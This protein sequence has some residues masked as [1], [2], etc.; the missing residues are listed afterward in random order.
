M[1]TS[2]TTQR[3]P[4]SL[5]RHQGP[6]L[7]EIARIALGAAIPIGRPS[8]NPP[9]FLEER[10]VIPA[11]AAELV[12]RYAAWSG[13]PDG[14]ALTLPPHMIAQWSIPLGTKI[15]RQTRYN[16]AT[17]INQGVSLRINGELPRDVPL[18]LGA[19]ITRLEESDGRARVAVSLTTGTEI[20]PRIIEA[21]LESTFPLP[22]ASRPQRKSR[23]VDDAEW[24]TIDHWQT[25][26][27]DGLKFA[28]LTGDFNP[29]H[30]VGIAGRLSPFKA[31]VLQGFGMLARTF[32]VLNR[33]HPLDYLDVRFLKP[34]TLPSSPVDV[35]VH[36]S[37]ENSRV[38]VVGADNRV[39]LVGTFS[40]RFRE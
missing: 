19:S 1:A 11:P 17:I 40:H 32:E 16:V 30:W 28:I 25:S 14:Y 18:H 21:V 10:R 22:G 4:L 26:R 36:V 33:S 3:V 29:I 35:Q 37:A 12:N 8:T 2:E 9:E 38:R 13:T 20:E 31:T 23:P 7:A 24:T 39:H 15:L 5:I 27:D 6:M 34:I